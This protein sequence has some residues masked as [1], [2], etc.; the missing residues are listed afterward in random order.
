MENSR[1]HDDGDHISA[2]DG[3]VVQGL[4]RNGDVPRAPWGAGA[5]PAAQTNS[6]LRPSAKHDPL[7][8]SI[9]SP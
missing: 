9:P 6:V 8:G 5:L 3:D 2:R 7:S 4:D 1:E